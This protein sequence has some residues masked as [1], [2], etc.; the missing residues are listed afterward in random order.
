VGGIQDGAEEHEDDELESNSQGIQLF[1][2]VLIKKIFFGERN[3]YILSTAV[4]FET[5]LSKN[6]LVLK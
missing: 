4:F 2:F 6:R 3:V 1:D 5:I